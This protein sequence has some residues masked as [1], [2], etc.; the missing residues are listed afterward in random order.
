MALA[1]VVFTKAQV[2]DRIRKVE[3]GVDEFR[4]WAENRAES[5]QSTAQAAKASG[6]TRG[7]TATESQKE[8][9]R[10]KKDEL[11]DALGD[12][13]RSTNR[14]RRKF[15]PTDKWMETRP[16]VENVLDDARKIN[17]VMVRGKYG[18]QAERYWGVL[19]TAVNDLARC[20]NLTPLGCELHLGRSGI[21]QSGCGET[22]SKKGM[23]MRILSTMALTSALATS[24]LLLASHPAVAQSRT[25][26]GDSISVTVTI[27]AIEQSTR[28]LTVKDDKG[29]YETIQAP[30]EMKRFSELKVGDKITARYYD[31][32]VV[33]LKKPGE[34]AVDVDSAALTRS[35]GAAAAGTVAAQRTITVTVTAKDPKANAVTVKGPNNYVY[36][37]KVA[38]KKTFNLLKVG[39]QLDMTWTEAVLISVD[40]ARK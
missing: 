21:E 2:A 24:A 27:E 6:R 30:P 26:E 39:D 14:L 33:R 1:Q 32:V 11:D 22:E 9:A 36:S 34:A 10:E 17:Q 20:Y 40:P 16:Q 15:D 4:K 5:G 31:N 18:T 7:R 29:I 3:D 19:R 8:V 25:I 13:N 37:R 12:L 38:D 35:K 28:T 23:R